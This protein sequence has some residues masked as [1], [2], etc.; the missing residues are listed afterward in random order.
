MKVMR[1]IVGTEATADEL[2]RW[3]LSQAGVATALIG[4]H[5]I[6]ALEEN[7][8][9]VQAIGAEARPEMGHANRAE[10]E[11]RLAHLSGPHALCWARPGYTDG[12][13]C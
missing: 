10:L 5:G 13:V 4:H 1:D 8:R 2:L 11:H 6:A 9:I 3:A 7:L 12:V